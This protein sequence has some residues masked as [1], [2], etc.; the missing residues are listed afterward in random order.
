MPLAQKAE[1]LAVGL[2]HVFAI[3]FTCG[4]IFAWGSNRQG[5]INPGSL[6]D[7]FSKPT[8]M[9]WLYQNS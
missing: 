9:S 8:E 1:I 3:N 6:L 4:K 7:S 2:N 5:Q